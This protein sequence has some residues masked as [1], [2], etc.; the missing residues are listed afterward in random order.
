MSSF[1]ARR[2]AAQII[3]SIQQ[4]IDNIQVELDELNQLANAG[5]SQTYQYPVQQPSK[6][7]NQDSEE[8]KAG[9]PGTYMG[10]GLGGTRINPNGTTTTM[11]C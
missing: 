3:A 8:F 7:L 10:P 4:Q 2:T 9:I 6:Y 11:R 5:Q 1:A